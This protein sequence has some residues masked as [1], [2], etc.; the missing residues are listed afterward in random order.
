[1]SK[2]DFVDK[3]SIEDS[4]CLIVIMTKNWIREPLR[5]QELEY[6]KSLGKPIA[7]AV[8]DEVDP[9]PYLKDAK[10]IV[11]RVFNREQVKSRTPLPKALIQ[12]F[13][14][15]LEEKLEEAKSNE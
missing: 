6:A 10:V 3:K 2:E 9:D 8:F 7:V 13:F 1:M 14:K 12:D 5:M 15:E 11:K 4:D